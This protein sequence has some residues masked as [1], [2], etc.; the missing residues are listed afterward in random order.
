MS[1]DESDYA[2]DVFISHAREDK[3]EF[4]DSL[5]GALEDQRSQHG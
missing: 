5:A 4:V 3:Q 2:Y 1:Q